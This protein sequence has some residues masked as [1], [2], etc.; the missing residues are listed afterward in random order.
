M[1]AD[2][3]SIWDRA[4]HGS[5]SQSEI[6]AAESVLRSSDSSDRHLPILI[7]GVTRKPEPALVA[8]V[9]QFLTAGKNEAER[10]CALR[11]LCRYWGLWSKYLDYV[12]MKI[13]PEEFESDQGV[14]EESFVLLGEYLWE[15]PDRGAWR[16]LLS[17]YDSAVA[18]AKRDLEKT[19]YSSICVGLFGAK[20]MLRREIRKQRHESPSE[21]LD[22]ARL[23]AG[24]TRE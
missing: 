12:L 3:E 4:K 15:H 10:Y 11:V 9:D 19:A 2:F 13:S 8:L 21:I 6:A 22:A 18:D 20:E 17:V 5:V 7:L 24:L 23:K 14:A 1:I 16:R